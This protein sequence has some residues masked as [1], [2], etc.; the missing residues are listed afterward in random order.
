[1]KN[2]V[3]CAD[4]TRNSQKDQTNVYK[5][6]TMLQEDPDQVTCYDKGVGT[7]FGNILRGSIFGRGLA[8]NVLDGFKFISNNYT[9]GDRIFLFGFSRGAYTVRSLASMISLCGLAPKGSSWRTRKR[10][11]KAYKRNRKSDFDERMDKIQSDFGTIRAE[12]EAICVW[13]T[14]GSI[15]MQTR[16]RDIRK[17]LWHEYHRMTVYPQVRAIYHA[18]SLDER[19]TQFYP[20][21]LIDQAESEDTTVEEVWFAGVH[22]DVG[23]GFRSDDSSLGDIALRWMLSRV[24]D[25]LTVKAGMLE[26]LKP[27][28]LGRMHNVERGIFYSFFRKKSRPVRRGSVLHPSV[29][30]R[31]ASPPHRHHQHREPSGNY[32]PLSLAFARFG[33]PPDFGIEGNY[34]ISSERP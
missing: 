1:M 29:K 18:V 34:R 32:E 23:G 14:V 5:T 19:R 10:F 27:D 2:I 8:I 24:S 30:T 31:M 15:G 21:L 11:W 33:S 13:D 22:S 7:R 12:V 20:H 16:M 6:Y 3:F 28:P 26:G 4:G 25:R 9:E 17:K